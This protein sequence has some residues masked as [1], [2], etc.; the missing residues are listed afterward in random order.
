M[1]ICLQVIKKNEL[2]RTNKSR[3]APFRSCARGLVIARLTMHYGTVLGG[4]SMEEGRLGPLSQCLTFD[5]L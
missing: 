2:E 4:V 3:N 5:E 1:F